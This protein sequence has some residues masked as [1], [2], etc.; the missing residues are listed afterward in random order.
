MS[1]ATAASSHA[2]RPVA[3]PGTGRRGPTF[4]RVVAAEW[5]KL[6]SLRSPFVAAA[7]TVLVS[8]VLT[9]LSANASSVDPGFD[10][11]GSLTAG[12]VLAQVGPLVLGVLVGTG[13]FSTGTFRTTFTAVPRRLPVLAAQALV[14]AAFAL[15]T[16]VLAVGAAVVGILP[17]AASRGIEPELTGG[18]TPQVLAGMT[19]FL[20][21]MALLGQ[22]LGALLRRAVP[23][24][25]TAVVLVLVL[26]VALVLASEVASGPPVPGVSGAA[27]EISPQEAAVN[28]AVTLLP[29]GAGQL[30]TAPGSEGVEGAPDLG[31]WGGGAVLAGWVL[32]PLGAAAVRLRLRDV[33]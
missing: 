16:A 27:T 33:T 29:G 2:S 1:A 18:G 3:R 24:A 21:G 9:Y 11:L 10:P 20:V 13:E 30:L 8:G 17:A 26:P 7:A 22:A 25:V 6:T 5:T 15:L 4:P 14:T 19:A 32:V 28:T 12:L 31:P 23:A